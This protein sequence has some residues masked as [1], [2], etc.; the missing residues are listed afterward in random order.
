[1]LHEGSARGAHEPSREIFPSCVGQLAEAY[2]QCFSQ[3]VY[4]L[5]VP[6][7]VDAI[8]R[9]DIAIAVKG[10]N[11][12]SWRAFWASLVLEAERVLVDD[13]VVGAQHKQN[14]VK[15]HVAAKYQ[16]LKGA[17]DNKRSAGQSEA[18]V[19]TNAAPAPVE[20]GS[21]LVQQT[22]APS[23]TSLD[24]LVSLRQLREGRWAPWLEDEKGRVKGGSY[25]RG[26]I[27]QL[28]KELEAKYNEISTVDGEFGDACHHELFMG[29]DGDL[30]MTGR[31]HLR[32]SFRG[33][34]THTPTDGALLVAESRDVKFWL[35]GTEEA[36]NSNVLAPAWWVRSVTEE[37]DATMRADIRKA[38]MCFTWKR[39]FLGEAINDRFEFCHYSLTCKPEYYG[40]TVPLTENRHPGPDSLL[41]ASP[42]LWQ[43]QGI[44][45]G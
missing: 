26:T 45:Q 18:T 39:M 30:M 29:G 3:E 27:R 23:G 7:V 17:S 31:Q 5:L 13:R 19:A 16:E 15:R 6:E 9:L 12:D 1:M 24:G 37:Q 20:V 38:T 41:W 4:R 22:V 10:A 32:I 25:P 8:A 33:R 35:V 43:E 44:R 2:P 28:E 34:I 14:A 40:S 36:R 11:S 21:E 42:A